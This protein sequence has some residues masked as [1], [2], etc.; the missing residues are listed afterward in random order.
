MKLEN[1]YTDLPPQFH[2][3]AFAAKCFNPQLIIYN[4][5]LADQLGLTIPQQNE[6]LLA[7]IF[8]GQKLLAGPPP[9]SQVYAAHQFGNFVPQLGDGRAMLLGEIID[10]HQQ[11]FDISLKG[12]GPTPYSRNGDGKSALGPVLREYILSE[13]MYHLAVPTTRA[14]CCVS[15][16]DEVYRERALSGAIFTRVAASHIR[17]GTFQYFAAKADSANLQKLLDYSVNRHYPEINQSNDSACK[18]VLFLREVM[19]VQS[20]LIAKWMSLGFIHGVMNTDNTT[21][22]G[23]TIDYGPCAF[24]DAY[25]SGQVYSFI[26]KMGRYSYKNQAGI[27]QWNLTRLAECLIPLVHADAKKAIPILES[28]LANFNQLYANILAPIMQSKLGLDFDHKNNHENSKIVVLWLDY[29]ETEKLDFTLAFRGL[30]N[31]LSVDNTEGIDPFYTP[32]EKLFA[33]LKLWK[34]SCKS[35]EK[36]LKLLA[37]RMNSINPIVI[38]RNHQVEKAI[39]NAYAGDFELFSTLNQA[40][41]SPFKDIEQFKSLQLPPQEDEKITATFCGT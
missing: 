32:T 20:K 4:Q 8:S 14:L 31:M 29:L 6:Q 1:T 22:T 40:L 13:A 19:Q 11:R 39:K 10:P 23:E 37:E 9:I 15:T 21:I 17:I 27:I 12:S 26:D 5:K 16:G 41:A 2:A 35:Q 25:K 3:R 36:D 18:A 38:P 7:Q 24:M 28:E 33:F 34:N 30:S